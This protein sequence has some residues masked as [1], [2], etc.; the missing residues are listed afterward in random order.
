MD[1]LTYLTC[2]SGICSIKDNALD[3]LRPVLY[4]HVTAQKRRKQNGDRIDTEGY[5]HV[6]VVSLQNSGEHHWIL[7]RLTISA[8]VFLSEIKK[9]CS[10]PQ[11][12]PPNR[13]VIKL[14]LMSNTKLE[15]ISGD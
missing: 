15:V 6:K 11:N 13:P 14:R 9:H 10:I 8:H 4:C 3:V 5:R 7:S 1:F 12:L 2:G